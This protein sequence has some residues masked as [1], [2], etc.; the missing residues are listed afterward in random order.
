MKEEVFDCFSPDNPKPAALPGYKRPYPF[1]FVHKTQLNSNELKR[2]MRWG[3][4]ANGFVLLQS[5]RGAFI[6]LANAFLVPA[7]FSTAGTATGCVKQAD[8]TPLQGCR[9][10]WCTLA[11]G[12]AVAAGAPPYSDCA[13]TWAGSTFTQSSLIAMPLL[14]TQL[15]ICWCLPVI[16]TVCDE[17]RGG[18][19]AVAL[20]GTAVSALCALACGITIAAGSWEASL[21]CTFVG[22]TLWFLSAGAVFSFLPGLARSTTGTVKIAN[23][24]AGG[25][26]LFAMFCLLVA[27]FVSKRSSPATAA[28]A[29]AVAVGCGMMLAVLYAAPRLGSHTASA[30][31]DKIA[32]ASTGTRGAYDVG[33]GGMQGEKHPPAAA[34]G[35]GAAGG[36]AEK[37]RGGVWAAAAAEAAQ[38]IV[39]PPRKRIAVLGSLRALVAA[40]Q[41]LFRDFPETRTFLAA[42][43][44]EQ[45]AQRSVIF[46]MS[47]YFIEAHD[48]SQGELAQL[49]IY[50]LVLAVIGAFAMRQVLRR[51]GLN[52]KRML[53]ATSLAKV[54]T[55]SLLPLVVRGV[56]RSSRVLTYAFTLPT[57]LLFAVQLGLQRGIFSSIVPGGSEA[58]YLGLLFFAGTVLAWIPPLVYSLMDGSSASIQLVFAVSILLCMWLALIVLCAFDLEKARADVA[59]FATRRT[60]AAEANARVS[61]NNTAGEV[62][63]AK[64]GEAGVGLAA[65]PIAQPQAAV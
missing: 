12:P 43:A 16:G 50:I 28:M 54:T 41:R 21:V 5:S 14:A 23:A 34:E 51:E 62:G 15:V 13:I 30:G 59:R 45:A 19:R 7:I 26:V 35:A 61:P 27:T 53:V 22:L 4:T 33:S 40:F 20:G 24:A 8:D 17:V 11:P 10:R 3:G 60:F 48:F 57:G 64:E 6:A 47:V 65:I 25:L 38:G 44:L 18:S 29:G 37:V 42:Y 1:M 55:L 49:S 46:L 31:R 39:M 63:D 32:T 36:G 58:E 9:S 52:F 2:A 56:G